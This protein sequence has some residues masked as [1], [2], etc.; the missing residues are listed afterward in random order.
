M[1]R[2]VDEYVRQSG[3][4]VTV[5]Y[6]KSIPPVHNDEEQCEEA[7]LILRELIGDRVIP[8][9]TKCRR[10]EQTTS[11][12]FKRSWGTVLLPGFSQSGRGHKGLESHSNL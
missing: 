2:I 7:E 9:W 4:H 5:E 3:S 8:F 11:L 12:A 6:V 1:S 10:T